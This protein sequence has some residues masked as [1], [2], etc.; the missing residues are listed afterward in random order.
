MMTGLSDGI[1]ICGSDV[2][3]EHREG[4][5]DALAPPILL[6]LQYPQ[7]FS[8]ELQAVEMNPCCDTVQGTGENCI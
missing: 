4:V 2:A 1:C 5:W 6:P 7:N 8:W 3:L